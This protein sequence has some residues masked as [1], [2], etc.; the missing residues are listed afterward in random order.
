MCSLIIELF[1]M[2]SAGGTPYPDL[3]MNELFYSALKRG[4]RMSKPSHASDEV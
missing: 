3:P 1:E 2:L 4:Y